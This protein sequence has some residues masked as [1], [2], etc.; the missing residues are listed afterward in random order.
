MKVTIKLPD[1]LFRRAK[2]VAAQRGNTLRELVIEGLRAAI[3]AGIA[4][5]RPTLTADEASVATIGKHGLPVLR[6]SGGAARAKVTH[7]LVTRIRHRFTI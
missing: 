6:R 4:P 7:A 1:S 3:G 2:T 5:A